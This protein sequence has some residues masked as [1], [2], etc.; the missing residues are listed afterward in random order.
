MGPGR[1]T[2]T[3]TPRGTSASSPSCR[4][5]T[6]ARRASPATTAANTP[7][8]KAARTTAA[9]CHA[10]RATACTARRRPEYQ[11]VKATQT[12]L[13]ATCHRAQV[14]KTERAVAH[15]P[16]REGKMTCTSCHNPHGSIT[17]VKAL[18]TGSSVG[19]MLHHLPRGDAGAGALGARAG[20]RELHHL[21]RPAR[22]VERPHA[23]RSHADALSAL[24]RRDTP[25]VVDLRQGR[26]HREQEQPD[27]RPLVCELPFEHSRVEPSIRPVLHALARPH[28]TPHVCDD[29][30]VRHVQ[31][32]AQQATPPAG[33]PAPPRDRPRLPRTSP[34]LPRTK[35]RPQ[36][37]RRLP[38]SLPLPTRS[39]GLFE[40]A[41]NQFEFGGRLD[42]HFRRPRAV[43]AISRFP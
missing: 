7:A 40:H 36:T 25:S 17:N 33:A 42:H 34:R 4:R 10:R 35:P 24:P 37:S 20:A 12:Q 6:A 31:R 27:V 43:S 3:T 23:D 30:C 18:K 16:V 9:T 8:G 21:P 32:L 14:A 2:W 5:T 41:P 28:A 22:I 39:P 19:E 29:V 26:D 15:M 11:L 13:C 1:R 38:Q